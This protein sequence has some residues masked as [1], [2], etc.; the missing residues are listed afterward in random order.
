MAEACA[1]DLWP[2]LYTVQPS[3]SGQPSR[4][5]GP[6]WLGTVAALLGAVVAFLGAG[7]PLPTPAHTN[8]DISSLPYKT[9]CIFYRE[10]M[11]LPVNACMHFCLPAV[12]VCK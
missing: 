12:F 5:A 1:L 2:A 7:G 10:G 4:W 9:P 8:T 11:K 6:S 3:T